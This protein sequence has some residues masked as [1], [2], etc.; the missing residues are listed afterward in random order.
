ME[1]TYKM[2]GGDG[3]EYGPVTL[4]EMK[5]WIVDGRVASRTQVWRS[6]QAR[7]LPAIQY[8]ELHPEIGEIEAMS[9]AGE[10]AVGARPVGFLMRVGAYLLDFFLLNML[11][12]L[13]WG[14]SKVDPDLAEIKTLQDLLTAME[15]FRGEMQAQALIQMLYFVLMHWQ[16]GATLG[17]LAI[18]ARVTNADGTR[19]GLGRS[20][21]R[22][23]ATI[24]NALTCGIGYL[25]VAFRPDRR[26]LHDLIAGTKVVYRE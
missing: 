1:T 7:W 5:A 26:G 18:R 9:S 10:R 14:P 2:I 13:I 15:P 4:S 25:L 21:L 12:F 23:F 8:Q 3:A 20:F 22:W 19:L 16:F 17:K 6:D 11:F 24:L